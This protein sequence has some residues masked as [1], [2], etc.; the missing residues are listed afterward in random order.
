MLNFNFYQALMLSFEW[1]GISSLYQSTAK[2]RGTP[3]PSQRGLAQTG[4]SGAR[5]L[6][7]QPALLTPYAHP[8]LKA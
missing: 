7:T 6:R 2:P 5:Q 4:Y 1:K 8:L 3:R